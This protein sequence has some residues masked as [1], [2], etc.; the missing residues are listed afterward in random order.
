V[1]GSSHSAVLAIRNL[2]EA[3]T[4]RVINFSRSPLRYAVDYGD[5]ILYD[6]TGL[7]GK[8]A[9]WARREMERVPPDRLLRVGADDLTIS[10]YLPTCTKVV[11]GIG[12]EPRRLR[13]EGADPTGYDQ[14]NGVIAPGLFGCGIAFPER[15]RDRAGNVEFNVGLLKF[16]KFLDRVVPVW[17]GG[18]ERDP[19]RVASQSTLARTRAAVGSP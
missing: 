4:G 13:V 1:F 16:A 19:G 10:Q 11:Y 15:I 6:N 14:T 8:T 12:F 17:L 2:L 18:A 7:K 3:G 5:W 9:E